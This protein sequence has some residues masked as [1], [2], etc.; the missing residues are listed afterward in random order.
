MTHEELEAASEALHQASRTATD[1]ATAARL[2]EHADQLARL[3]DRDAGPDHGRL[4]RHQH[5]LA[6][7]LDG[8]DEGIRDRVEAAKSHISAYRETVEGV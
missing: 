1:D 4:A 2:R 6:D 5:A 3:A 7:I 8:G